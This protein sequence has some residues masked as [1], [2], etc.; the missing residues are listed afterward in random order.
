M[1]DISQR[2]VE[3]T[4]EP[5]FGHDSVCAYAHVW[6]LATALEQAG[7]ADRA[8]VNEAL[9]NDGH[10]RRSGAVVSPAGT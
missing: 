4:K 10:A 3:R 1:A 8:K 9:R 2:F 7:A 6:I 5:W